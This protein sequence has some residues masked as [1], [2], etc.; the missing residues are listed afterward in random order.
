[1]DREEMKAIAREIIKYGVAVVGDAAS[2]RND[3]QKA[4]KVM[5]T[6]KWMQEKLERSA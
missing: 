1:M 6:A 3:R 5:E 4:Q 2:L